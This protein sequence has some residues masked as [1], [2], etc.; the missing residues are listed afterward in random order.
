MEFA[1]YGLT[2]ITA[3][4][5]SNFKNKLAGDVNLTYKY[6]VS[7][8]GFEASDKTEYEKAMA[9]YIND[10]SLIS[11][12]DNRSTNK[13]ICQMHLSKDKTELKAC[14]DST[15]SAKEFLSFD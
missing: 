1:S 11:E 6:L 3:E 14:I 4:D 10:I 15:T 2:G 8:M 5:L 12:D 7:K 9:L 13:F